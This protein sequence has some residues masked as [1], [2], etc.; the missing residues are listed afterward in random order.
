MQYLNDNESLCEVALENGI[1]KHQVKDWFKRFSGEL[2][3]D[4]FSAP[5]TE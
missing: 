5:K 2:V 3:E 4:I 1:T